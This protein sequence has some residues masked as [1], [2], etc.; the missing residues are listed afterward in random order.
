LKPPLAKEYCPDITPDTTDGRRN[1]RRTHDCEQ[2][3]HMNV[4]VRSNRRCERR[5]IRYVTI[6]LDNQSK[7]KQSSM[8]QGE[9]RK[10]QPEGGHEKAKK[11]KKC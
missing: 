8:K 10:F 7:R 4:M 11:T 9:K 2:D 6:S 1:E 3:P 5:K